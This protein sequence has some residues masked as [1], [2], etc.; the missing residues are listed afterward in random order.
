MSA[1]KGL[2]TWGTSAGGCVFGSCGACS[3]GA[4]GWMIAGTG[5][6]ERQRQH[7]ST[8][9]AGSLAT[10]LPQFGVLHKRVFSC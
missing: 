6:V 9:P 7:R 2:T 10:F 8:S 1:M 5:D 3:D 4:L